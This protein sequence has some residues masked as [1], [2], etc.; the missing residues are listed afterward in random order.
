MIEKFY[1]LLLDLLDPSARLSEEIQDK[2]EPIYSRWVK[3]ISLIIFLALPAF[4]ILL[5]FIVDQHKEPLIL[6]RTYRF[7]TAFSI[8]FL[9]VL[10][11]VFKKHVWFII[12]NIYIAALLLSFSVSWSMS[13]TPGYVVHTKWVVIISSVILLLVAKGFIIP[14]LWTIIS[15]IIASP[16][17]SKYADVRPLVTDTCFSI[18]LIFFAYVT[19]KVLIQSFVNKLLY[20]KYQQDV[21]NA[22]RELH[23]EV[24]RF[25]PP[26]LVKKIEEQT[27][28]DRPI[29]MV[30]DDILRRHKNDVAVLFSDIRNFSE[31]STDMEFVE[32]ELI[33]SSIKLIDM[34][35]ANMGVAKQ[36]G[37]AIFAYYSTEGPHP[38]APKEGLLR[39]FK[40]A[41]IGCLVEKQRVKKLGR[42]KS[43]RFFSIAYGPAFIGNMASSRHREATVIGAPANLAARMDSLTKE[44]AFKPLVEDGRKILVCDRAKTVMD[45]FEGKLVFEKIVLED[46]GITIKSFP[47]EKFIYLF[48]VTKENIEALNEILIANDI[49]PIIEDDI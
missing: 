27:Q 4:F 25:V 46:I 22:Q 9:G 13:F 44:P 11:L 35:E 17:W 1:F 16:F 23:Y 6:W 38:D 37:D 26:V 12:F 32:K 3:L 30:V 34:I 33:P 40:D 41:V 24:K 20:D 45:E 49:D 47:D 28:K 48:H 36:I 18:L 7:L 39:A 21:I 19:K 15:V 5:F 42:D 29:S 43:E 14:T 10:S 31:R 2:L 8:L